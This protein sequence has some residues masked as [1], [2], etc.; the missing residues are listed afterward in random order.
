VLLDVAV[1][2][3]DYLLWLFGPAASVTGLARRVSDLEVDVEDVALIAL[4]LSTG[5]VADVT[6]DYFDHSYH[7]GCR[8]VGEHATAH[9]SWEEERLTLIGRD[10]SKRERAVPSDVG[11]AY[12]VQLER[13]LEAAGGRVQPPTSAGEARHVI[14]VIDAARVSSREGRRVPI[15]PAIVLRPAERADSGR[16]RAWRN[17]PETRRWSRMPGE[18]SA[19]EHDSWLA[20]M[21]ADGATPLW[22]AELEATPIG[23]VRVSR[24]TGGSVELHATLAPEVRGRGLA[25]PMLIEASGRVLADP[26]VQKLVAHVKPGNEASMRAFSRAG[27]KPAGR[28]E[29]G[30][31]RLERGPSR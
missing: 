13:F 12:R 19:D 18:V 6:V 30:L 31:L 25:A 28:D 26:T 17:D 27:F 22:I 14:A 4:E 8:I 3:L 7:R 10:A 1:H 20:R 29:A 23:Q 2:E 15:A 5:P 11:P 24:G 21:L 9:W 16:L